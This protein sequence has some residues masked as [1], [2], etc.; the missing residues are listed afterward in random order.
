MKNRRNYYRILHVQ[1]DAPVAVIKASYRTQMQKLKLHPDLGGDDWNAA[2][3]NEAYA[4]LSNTKKRAAYDR[5]WL[6]DK[7]P[8]ISPSRARP[9]TAQ[10]APA[11]HNRHDT[12]LCPFCATPKPVKPGYG[13]ATDC[14]GCQGPLQV[15]GRLR[16]A[17]SSRRALERQAYQASMHYCSAPGTSP[18]SGILYDLS[19]LGLQFQ[20]PECLSEGQIIRIVSDTL[21]AIARVSHSTA[22]PTGTG[23]LT[24]VEF[25]TLRF[26]DR[27][28]TF[29][30]GQV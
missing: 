30:S 10:E 18:Q 20:C 27:C 22:S 29:F 9:G 1:A 5:E 19:P 6:L 25:L 2:V 28:G 21:A 4:I 3:L 17:D 11:A 24:G 15:A 26:Q 16:L 12:A 23:Y 13:D 14:P 8:D 7:D